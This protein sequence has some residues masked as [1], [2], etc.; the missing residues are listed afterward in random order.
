MEL[1]PITTAMITKDPALKNKSGTTIVEID[2]G[3]PAD[4]VG[5]KVND[6]ILAINS[7]P[8]SSNVELD[9]AITATNQAS[10]ILLDVDRNGQRM[11]VTLK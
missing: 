7:L 3:L 11:L 8:V 2:P 4:K 10:T 5:L 1:Q 9:K 6:T